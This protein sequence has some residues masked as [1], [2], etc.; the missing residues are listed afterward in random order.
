MFLALL[1]MGLC[2]TLYTT[3]RTFFLGQ[4]V[5]NNNEY[6]NRIRSGLLV[7]R[8]VSMVG[9]PGTYWVA[10]NFIWGW[11]LPITQL[12]EAYQQPTGSH[13]LRAI[14][15]SIWIYILP[16]CRLLV[17][18][19]VW[20][21]DM[22]FWMEHAFWPNYTLFRPENQL[23]FVWLVYHKVIDIS[24]LSNRTLEELVIFQLIFMLPCLIWLFSKYKRYQRYNI[25]Q[26]A[27][28]FLQDN[29]SE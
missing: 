10:N 7:S 29:K 19:L 18:A 3:L 22:Y 16:C 15:T 21:Y 9:E 4:A 27:D 17:S 26:L 8:M 20:T 6:T 13:R 23:L 11:L 2:P 28:S 5:A 25:D 1:V 24:F 14:R 12:D